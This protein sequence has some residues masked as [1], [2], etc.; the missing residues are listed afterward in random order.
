MFGKTSMFICMVF[1]ASVVDS[2]KFTLI[3]NCKKTI[4]VGQMTLDSYLNCNLPIKNL[5]RLG[6]MIIDTTGFSEVYFFAN[7]TRTALNLRTNAIERIDN[8][9]VDGLVDDHAGYADDV[10]YTDKFYSM[11][12]HMITD[13]MKLCG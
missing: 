11:K 2:R 13:N 6:K 9:T 1:L 8:W 5:P 10:C 7:G 4:Q 3:N 12:Y